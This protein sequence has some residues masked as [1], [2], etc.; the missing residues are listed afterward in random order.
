MTYIQSNSIDTSKKYNSI[1]IGLASPESILARSYGEVLKPETINYRSYKPEKDGL[2]CEKIFGPVKDYEC[3]CGKYKGIRY[4]GIICDRCGVEVTRKKV[5]RERMGHITLAVPVV[6]IWYLRSIPSKIS[7]LAG[8]STKD[9]E[10]VIY[11]EMFMIIEPGASGLEPFELIE[12]EEYL[13]IEE[14]FGYMAVS[15]EDRDNENYFYAT[16]GGEA[17]KEMLSKLNIM[18][19]K[20]E[21]VDIVKTSKSKQKR[22]DALKRLKVV[23]S[24]VP[25]PTK[26]RLNKPDWMIVS[27]LPV[28][29]PELRPL[30][31]LEGGRFAASDLNDLY[32]RIIIRNN[33]LKQLME[34]KAPDVILRNEKRMLQEAVD[35]LFDNNRRKTAIRSGSR[36]PLKSLSDML[37]GKTGRFRQNLLGKRVDYSARSVIVVGPS[38]KL[39]ECGM[40]KNMALELFKPH[41][42]HELMARGYTQTPR[43]AKLMVENREPVV[44]KVLEYVVEDHPVLLNR[45]PTLHRLG[46]QAFQ[47]VLVEGKAIQLHPLVCSAFNADFDGDQMAVH[48]PLSLEA[49]MEARMLMLASHNILHPANGQPIAVPSQDMVLG[50]YYLSLP[51]EG[52]KGEGKFFSSIQEGLLAYENKAVGL[53]AIINVRH[54]GVWIKNTTVGRVIFNSIL[55]EGLD[56]VNDLIDKKTLTEI[57]NNAYIITGNYQTV[58]F[59]DRLKELGFGIATVSGVSIAIS[60]VL[61]PDRKDEILGEAQKEVDDIKDKFDRHILTDGE[62]Y[63]K[64]IDI[65]THATNR[66]AGSMMDALKKD[67]SGFNPVYMM[68][69]SGARGSQDQ[70]KQLAG[71]RG[72]MAKPQKSMK[73]GVGEIIESPIT[74]NFKEGLSVFEYFISTHGAR[75]GLA[76]TALKTADAGYL[77]RR[78]V[79][80]AQDVVVYITDCETINGIAISDLKEGEEI[81][82]TLSDRI[83]GRTVL[84]DFIIKGD[85][86]VK[87]GALIEQKEAE[88]IEDSGVENIQIRSILTCE[89]KRGCCAKCYG[90]DLS[91]HQLVDI[92]TAVGIRAAQSIGEPGTQLTLR[93]FHIGG[94]ATRIIEQSEMFTKRAGKVKFSENYDYADTIDELGTKVR[95]C[96]VRHAKLFILNK[97]GVESASFNV[98]YGSTV[99]VNDG[100][101]LPA[102]ATLIQWDPYTDSILARET[103]LVALQDFIEGETYAVESVEGGK[104]QMVVVEARNRKLSP[105]IEIVDKN[106]KILAGGTILPVKATLVVKNGQKVERGQTL[107]KI[108]KDIGKTRDITGGLPRVA[109]LFESRKPSNP[110]VM[111]EIN[112]SIRFGETRRGIRKIHVLGVDGEERTYSIPYGKHVIVHEG[113]FVNAGTNLCEGAISPDDIL[114]VL[115]PAAVRDYLVNEI[116]EVYRLQGV[117]INDKHIEVIVSQMMQKVSVKETGDTWFLEEDRI[118]KREFFAENERISKMIIVNEVGD[119]DLEADTMIDR[120]EFL[121]INKELKAD[122]K[123]LATY[124]KTKPATFEPILMGIT[125][126]SLNTESFISAAS[127]QETTRVLT[128]ASTAGKT[129]YLQ[130]L[131]ENVAVGRLIPAGTGTPGIND[132]LVGVHDTDEETASELGDAVA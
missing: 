80:V 24:F 10:R 72:L 64:V 125:R 128:D 15:E 51:K 84:D 50:C 98:P 3:H 101:D 105:H 76:D 16:M 102:K 106:D 44:Y 74:S 31:P 78:L 79:D 92:G 132:I 85:V 45:A 22:A 103:G 109:E 127:F 7:Y 69:D 77:T 87:A 55:P 97:E 60:D 2:F 62:R 11:Y 99:F 26:K 32:R 112:G 21:L 54:N 12:E 39:H 94:T 48:L 124:R 96:M 126:A 93:T 33:R 108:P 29:P 14:Q 18:E 86:V 43:S 30:V 65:W 35:A 88:T 95:R 25:D 104:K 117:K 115:G 118:A 6:H 17:M 4:R 116:Q 37:R 75:K 13:D 91:T 52:D 1:T 81:I 41:M 121:E 57:V 8:K 46:I 47:P 38:L 83:L 120:S 28:I 110:A 53:H 71:M 90:W 66:V 131:K 49:Q 73:G 82:E 100:D 5:R 40:P 119:S 129:D 58:L 113:D 61:I 42:I 9:L 20:N 123:E 111:T 70:I 56:F 63:N 34:I 107:V 59:L 68:A 114:H 19:L 130:G 89:A 23:K 67:R 36:R 122:E 27:I